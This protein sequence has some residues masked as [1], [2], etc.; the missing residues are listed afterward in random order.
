MEVLSW[1]GISEIIGGS[2]LRSPFHQT[3]ALR[4]RTRTPPH[5]LHLSPGLRAQNKTRRRQTVPALLPA[6]PLTPTPGTKCW[7]QLGHSH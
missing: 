7:H 4:M 2:D 5:A 3:P 1:V 6:P